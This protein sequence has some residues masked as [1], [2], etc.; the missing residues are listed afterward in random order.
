MTTGSGG[1]LT[2]R[3]LVDLSHAIEQFALAA[4]PGEPL[5]VVALFQ[6]ASYFARER[7]V[8]GDIAQQAAMTIVAVAEDFA[9]EVPPGVHLQLIAQSD[10]L[11][12]EWSVTVLGAHGGATLVALDQETV[13][14]DAPTLEQGR[15]F[16]GRWSFRRDDAYREIVR[17][18]TELRLPPSAVAEIDTVLQAVVAEPEPARQQWWDGPLRLL[19]DRVESAVRSRDRTQ[20]AL[21]VAQAGSSERDPRTGLLTAA[22]LER[23]TAGLGYGTLPIGLVALRVLDIAAVRESY[24]MRAEMASLAVLATILQGLAGPADRVFRMGREDFLLVL[25]GR[26]D[27]DVLALTREI[28]ARTT[29]I[30]EQYPFVTLETAVTATVTRDRPLPIGRLFHDLDRRSAGEMSLPG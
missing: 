7:D 29:R 14:G 28:T 8:Y 9:P 6:K 24:G 26:R 10:P 1:T 22:Y 11:A 16:H 17:L 18:R 15:Q 4:E 20:A 23:W 2:K 5:I 21:A 3:V 19:A 12:R 27:D 25:P 30:E 13:S